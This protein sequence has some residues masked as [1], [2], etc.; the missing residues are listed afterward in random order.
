MEYPVIMSPHAPDPAEGLS[1][2]ADGELSPRELDELLAALAADGEA[3]Q[4]ARLDWRCIQVMGDAMRSSDLCS[5]ARPDFTARFA[6]RLALEP[7]L[8]APTPVADP[9]APLRPASRPAAV[10]AAVERVGRERLGLGRWRMASGFAGVATVAVLAG[11]LG[12]NLGGDS[13]GEGVGLA[14]GAG[15]PTGGVALVASD[16]LGSGQARGEGLSAADRALLRREASASAR[17]DPATGLAAVPT[18]GGV[19]LRDPALDAQIADLMTAHRQFGGAA[20]L[21]LPSGFARS[22][23]V[24]HPAGVGAQSAR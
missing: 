3:G 6:A 11:L 4:Q 19:V 10:E 24:D 21:G 17:T 20:A 14:S 8:L 2:L 18:T 7:A 9:V 1:R 15:V 23:T 5:A 16:G 22:A 12:F 13:Q